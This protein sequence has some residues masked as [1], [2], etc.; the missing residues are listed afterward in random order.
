MKLREYQAK[1]IFAQRGLTVPL[2]RVVTS[3]DE[4]EKAAAELGP[5]VL[6]PQLG[7]K[8]RGKVGGIGF[9]STPEEARA[10]AGRLLGLDI[11]GETVKVLLVEERKEILE[12]LYL[13][14]VVDRGRRCP[15]LMA[16]PAGGVDIEEVARNTPERIVKIEGS[17]LD[18]PT[19]EQLAPVVDML[20]TEVAEALL[21]L[22]EVFRDFDA[23]MVEI[24]P[25]VRTPTGLVAVDGVLNVDDDSL[26]RHPDLL[27]LK[28]DIPPDDPLA[29]EASQRSWSYIDLE[30][31]IAI[32][33]SGAGLT[34]AIVDLI[35]RAGS[36]AA[37]F[38][39]TAQIDDQGIIAAF[40]LLSRARPAKAWLVNIFAGL[41]RCDLLAEGIRS[42][43]TEHP[44]DAP[45]IVRMV[46]NQEE[47]GHAIL[48]EAGIEVVRGL[49]EA[50]DRVVAMAKGGAQ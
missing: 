26:A 13:S 8:G 42:Y 1:Q 49:E 17:L 45:L 24:N 38:L 33:S 11:K 43:L 28:E 6:K 50:V 23:E 31:D 5:C 15:I 7:V 39:D 29:E 3:A 34:M 48:A 30:G 37:N 35:G 20:G 46:G 22:Y 14:V 27:K 4:A 41:N 18:S 47:R 32:L 12:E 10:E 2:G 19:K 21:V 25:I 9:A 40:D 36:T 16:S 44:I